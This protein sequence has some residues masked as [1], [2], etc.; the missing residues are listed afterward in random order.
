MATTWKVLKVIDT[1][2]KKVVSI[3]EVKDGVEAKIF[4]HRIHASEPN[5][6]LKIGLIE[7]VKAERI[8]EA[9]E[10][11]LASTIDLSDFEILVNQ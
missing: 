5:S 2:E 1:A 3:Q 4:T 6:K 7:K 9:Q 10:T 8:K 11:S